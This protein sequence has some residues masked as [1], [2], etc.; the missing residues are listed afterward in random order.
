M[1]ANTKPPKNNGSKHITPTNQ[2]V[3]TQNP[4]K[5][6]GASTKPQQNNESKHKT[7]TNQWEQT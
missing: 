3:Q 4:T 1:S 5:T 7:P 2:W 6:M